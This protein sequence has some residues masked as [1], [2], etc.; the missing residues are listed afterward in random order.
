[1][2]LV[3]F[4][5]H[6][7]RVVRVR[8]ERLWEGTRSVLPT[9]KHGCVSLRKPS[10]KSDATYTRILDPEVVLLAQNRRITASVALDTVSRN[11][12]TMLLVVSRI[13]A[14]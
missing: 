14:L 6:R 11:P 7:D 8:K 9:N 1:M 5:R 13:E 10:G 2:H 3:Q 12:L 4:A